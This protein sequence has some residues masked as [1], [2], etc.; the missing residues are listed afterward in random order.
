MNLSALFLQTLLTVAPPGHTKFSVTTID[1][2]ESCSGYKWSSFY[3]SYVRPESFEE[4]KNRYSIIA[5]HLIKT[6]QQKLCLDDDLKPIPN[7]K[8]SRNFKGWRFV[9]LVS[10]TTG[11]MIAESGLRKDIEDG[12]GRSNKP[13]DD[14]GQG[15]G[16]GGEVCLVQIHPSVLKALKIDPLSF[17]GESNLDTCFSFGM[18]MFS[19]SRNVCAYR[20]HKAPEIEHNW[21]FETYSLYGTGNTC[22]SANN[23]KTTYRQNLYNAVSSDFG[24]RIKKEQKRI[25]KAATLPLPPPNN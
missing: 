14:G 8:R 1:C 5:E 25:S 4:G 19:K 23:G 24:A 16:A 21:V 20:A 13:S 2:G 18:D 12:N 10:I 3:N 11:S 6:A 9:D 15:L 17:L 7:C 22:T